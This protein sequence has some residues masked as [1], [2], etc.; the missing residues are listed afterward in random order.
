MPAE[1]DPID[2]AARALAHRDRSRHELEERLAR[3]GVDERRRADALETLERVG[4][5][6]DNRFAA[7]RAAA[8][9]ER[10]YGDAAIRHDLTGH[11][12]DSGAVHGAVAG[13]E[14]EADRARALVARLGRSAK[15]GAQLAR[16]GF[17][18]D[19]IE[20]ALGADVAQGP[21]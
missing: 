11:G 4:Y 1:R 17:A 18:E 12:V 13:L 10:G 21:E 5:V 2:I 19:S 14:P 16:K 9:T 20:A 3:A 15:T 8:L 6:D 7:A